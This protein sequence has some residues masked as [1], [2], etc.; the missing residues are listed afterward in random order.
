M[1]EDHVAWKL[2]SQGKKYGICLCLYHPPSPPF[3][4]T[5]EWRDAG[6]KET[7]ERLL[8]TSARNRCRSCTRDGGGQEKQ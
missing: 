4:P 2:P 8:M 5:E 3:L 6:E 1:A 7:G